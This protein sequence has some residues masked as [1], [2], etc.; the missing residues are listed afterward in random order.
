MCPPLWFSALSQGFGEAEGSVESVSLLDN[1]LNAS[2][3]FKST[4]GS[5]G[6]S[7]LNSAL[8]CS[9]NIQVRARRLQVC[10]EEGLCERGDKCKYAYG[11]LSVMILELWFTRKSTSYSRQ[12]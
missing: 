10:L 8:F 3:G 12:A 2:S 11:V 6:E 7:G 1:R 4:V 5:E 9:G